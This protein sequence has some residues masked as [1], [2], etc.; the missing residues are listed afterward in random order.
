MFVKMPTKKADEKPPDK[1]DV[2]KKDEDDEA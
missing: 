1:K 2:K